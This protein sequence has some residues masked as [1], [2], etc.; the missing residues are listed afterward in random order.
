MGCWISGQNER[1]IA[2]EE[3][4]V[5]LQIKGHRGKVEVLYHPT[6]REIAAQLV[7][8][9]GR[10]LAAEGPG[11][12]FLGTEERA[13]ALGGAAEAVVK[14]Y[15]RVG[16]SV[17]VP[18]HADAQTLSEI[19]RSYPSDSLL[20][21]TQEPGEI[22][23]Y[24]V[25]SWAKV[26]IISVVA[27]GVPYYDEDQEPKLVVECENPRCLFTGN[28]HFGCCRLLC[29]SANCLFSNKYHLGDCAQPC[30]NRGCK[31]FGSSHMGSCLKKE[32]SEALLVVNISALQ[33]A[34][35]LPADQEYSKETGLSSVF[36]FF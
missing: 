5:Q 14:A 11:L 15:V 30:Y 16:I 17:V 9:G 33:E 13:K 24:V 35:G 19:K 31:R 1:R 23:D 34:G 8:F 21:A 29:D 36:S 18:G 22:G 26:C 4:T 20:I 12:L 27:G 32:D 28:N 25:Y 3:T 6:S 2:P 10:Q 7:F